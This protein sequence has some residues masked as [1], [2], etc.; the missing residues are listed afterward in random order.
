MAQISTGEATKRR[1]VSNYSQIWK[2][3]RCVYGIS[4]KR[5]IYSNTLIAWA[6]LPKPYEE[7]S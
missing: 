7:D 3:K 6:E 4:N 1:V 5:Y 2:Y